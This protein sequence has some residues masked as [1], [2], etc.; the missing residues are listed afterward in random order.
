MSDQPTANSAPQRKPFTISQILFV[1]AMTALTILF[2]VLGLW[3]MQRLDEKLT[4]IHAIESRSELSPQ[5][6]PPVSEWATTD[7]DNVDYLPIR[8]TGTFDHAQTVF[9]F[10]SLSEPRGR[11]S[12]PGYLVIAP[13]STGGGTILVNRG[14]VP[15]DLQNQFAGGGGG[16]EGEVTITGL[17]RKDETVNSF[18]PPSDFAQRT[19]WV[20]NVERIAAFLDPVP[21]QLAPFMIDQSAGEAGALP[22]GGETRLRL[23]NRHFEYALTWF[24][25]AALTPLMLIVWWVRERRMTQAG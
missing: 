11:Y 10:T 8:A 23:T 3:Q 18:T 17:L 6:L 22:Q 14:F 2:V 25:L 9:V 19:E 15:Q 21:T 20:R 4:R 13:F 1:V 16:P 12:G 7:P 5:P 24:S